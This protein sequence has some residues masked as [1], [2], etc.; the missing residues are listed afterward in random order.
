MQ[1]GTG[2]VQFP[3]SRQVV[4]ADPFKKNP[5]GQCNTRTVVQENNPFSIGL[6]KGFT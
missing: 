1:S 2:L 6:F 3:V 5:T 4:I